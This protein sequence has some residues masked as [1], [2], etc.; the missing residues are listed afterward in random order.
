MS[1]IEFLDYS[2]YMRESIIFHALIKYSSCRISQIVH[3]AIITFSP[4]RL[5]TVIIVVIIE[6]P[7]LR[8]SLTR[9]GAS[10]T[11]SASHAARRV[12]D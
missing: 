8:S 4:N 1:P 10:K 2:I 12:S 11:P 7:S 6:C 5:V 9:A 3:R